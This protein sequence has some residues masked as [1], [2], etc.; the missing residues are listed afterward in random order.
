MTFWN[1]TLGYTMM[2]NLVY[3]D[4]LDIDFELDASY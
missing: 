4:T 2:E 1:E 3:E